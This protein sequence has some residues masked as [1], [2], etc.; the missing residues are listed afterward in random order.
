MS[1]KIFK[2][3]IIVRGNNK[4]GNPSATYYCPSHLSPTCLPVYDLG[5]VGTALFNRLAALIRINLVISFAFL[6]LERWLLSG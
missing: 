2:T 4:D 6:R 1:I 3:N 5:R